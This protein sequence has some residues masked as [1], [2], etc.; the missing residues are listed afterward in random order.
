[1]RRVSQY[2]SPIGPLLLAAEGDFLTEVRFHCPELPAVAEAD[3]VLSAAAMWLDGYFGKN[4]P[5]VD[6]LPLRPAGTPFQQTVWALLR[7][8]PWGRTVSYGALAARAAEALGKRAMSAQAIG[9]AVGRNPMAIVI[10]CH[11]VI[12]ADGSL[13]GFTG[14]LDIKRRLLAHEGIFLPK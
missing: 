14:G 3:P 11:R 7:E 5:P 6:T 1:M 13:A 9:G 2:N 8:I 10:P 4:P 12:G